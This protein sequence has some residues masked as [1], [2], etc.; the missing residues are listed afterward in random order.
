MSVSETL[1]VAADLIQLRGWKAGGGWAFDDRGPLC[2]EGAIAAAM[3]DGLLDYGFGNCSIGPNLCPAGMA[4]RD[5]LNLGDY[6]NPSEVRPAGDNHLYTWND[7]QKWDCDLETAV[8]VRTATEV[9]EV[10]RA[11]AL[12]ESARERETAAVSA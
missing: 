2:L 5:Y 10:L 12:V 4:V 8:P 3:G 7:R 6:V 11:T 9:V 1:N